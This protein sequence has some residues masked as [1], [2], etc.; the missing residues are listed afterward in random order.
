[1]KILLM[2]GSFRSKSK[3]LAI[4]NTLKEGFAEH[5]FELPRL[6]ALPFFSEDFGTDKPE[7]VLNLLESVRAADGIVVCS[8]EYNHSVP[9]VL[10]NAID[11]VSRPAFASVL[12]GKPVTVIT[13]AGSPIGGARAQAHIKLVFD[14]TLSLVHPCHEM[15]IGGIDSAFDDDLRIVDEQVAS[16]LKRHFADFVAFVGAPR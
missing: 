7:A 3:S 6:D 16:R 8:P 13:Q 2:S 15:T 1:M 12:K 9:A 4:L 14:S 5:A 10:K 11:W